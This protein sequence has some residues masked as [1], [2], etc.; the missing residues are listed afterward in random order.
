MIN[1]LV[2]SKIDIMGFW[3]FLHE[4]K[5]ILLLDLFDKKMLCMLLAVYFN[6]VEG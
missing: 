4:K 3:G 6:G 2:K 1:L 5:I